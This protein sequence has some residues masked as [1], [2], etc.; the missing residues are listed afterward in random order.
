MRKKRSSKI[1]LTAIKQ[2]RSHICELR[3]DS[4]NNL[5]E[6]QVE[7]CKLKSKIKSKDDDIARLQ[8]ETVENQQ[9]RKKKHHDFPTS[10]L[11]EFTNCNKI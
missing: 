5:S 1:A 3:Q 8:A 2:L 7:N 10:K 9:R 6:L 11:L 4:Q